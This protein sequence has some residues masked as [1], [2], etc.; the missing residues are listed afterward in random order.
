MDPSLKCALASCIKL[1]NRTAYA[2]KHREVC[3]YKVWLYSGGVQVFNKL[4]VKI[5]TDRIFSPT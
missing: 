3:F 1:P 5:K 2:C 4:E